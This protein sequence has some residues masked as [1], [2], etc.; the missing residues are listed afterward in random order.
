MNTEISLSII[1]PV[2]N[3]E[4]V[5]G[6]CIESLA[7]Q[8]SKDFEVI[9][10]DDGSSDKSP[11]MCDM[12]AQEFPNFSVIHLSNGG[13]SKARNAGLEKA[14]GR[15][16]SFI[17]SDDYVP[18]HYV[19]TIIREMQ[20]TELLMFSHSVNYDDGSMSIFK[21]KDQIMSNQED[22]EKY[23]LFLKRYCLQ[24][25]EFYGYIWNK[26]YRRDIIESKCIR[27]VENLSCREDNIFNES[28]YR[29]ISKMKVLSSPLYHYRFTVSGLTHKKTSKVDLLMIAR[30][31]DI[32]TESIGYEPLL[33]YE[34]K[35]VLKFYLKAGLPYHFLSL[36]QFLEIRKFVRRCRSIKLPAFLQ[37]FFFFNGILSYFI[38]TI[39][40]TPLYVIRKIKRAICGDKNLRL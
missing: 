16:V 6:E 23:L 14:I 36:G 39:S 33:N 22:L 37:L 13:V 28:Y 7:C 8:S 2:Y 40:L 12:F 30:G 27:F 24:K 38:Y 1:I 19:E 17:D 11:S 31:I 35:R 3:A 29:N 21:R 15:F 25:W 20:D 5:L 4:L 18:S 34:K 9:L 32:N 10:V 26:C